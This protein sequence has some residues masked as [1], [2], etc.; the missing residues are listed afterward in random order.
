MVCCACEKEEKYIA[1]KFCERSRQD[2][3]RRIQQ[4]SRI[5]ACHACLYCV[6]SGE[7]RPNQAG[8]PPG[9]NPRS[10]VELH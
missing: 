10:A 3:Y 4:A 6:Y 7:A 9:A 5:S 2:T 1:S 8:R